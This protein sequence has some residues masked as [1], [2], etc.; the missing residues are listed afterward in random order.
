MPWRFDAAN[1]QR[2]PLAP[3]VFVEPVLIL[4]IICQGFLHCQLLNLH[5]FG[6][7]SR[8]YY[9]SERFARP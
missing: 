1:V 3:F 5:G 9:S 2:A 8:W 6:M 7:R 4:Q